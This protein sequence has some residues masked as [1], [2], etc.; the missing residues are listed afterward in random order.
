MIGFWKMHFEDYLYQKKLHEP[1]AE[2]K[3]ANM[4]AEEWTMLDRQ[5]LGAVRLSLAKNVA[6]NIINDKTTYDL[7][8][9]LSNMYEKPSALN[10][11]FLIRQSVNTK[12]KK[13]ASVADHVNEFNAI[14][15]RMNRTLNE[16]VKRFQILEEERQGNEVSLAHLRVF[17]CDSY[18]KVKDVT[19]DNLDAKSVK[20]TFI[21]YSLDEIGYCFWDSKSHKVIQSKDITF[22]EDSLYGAKAATNSSNLTMPNQ[23][24]QVVLEDSLENLA[25]KSI[26]TEHGLSLEIIQ[27]L[28]GSSYTSE[29]SENNKSFED[30]ER[31]DKEDS[32]DRAS[33]EDGGSKGHFKNQ[34]PK[35]VASRD[36]EVHMTVKDYDDAL[37][38]CVE[39]IVEDRIMDFDASFHATFFKEELEKFK[40]YSGKV[41]LAYDKTLDIARVGDVLDEEGYHVGFRN[42]Q[43]KVTKGSLVVAC[44][45][46]R[47]SLYMV[48]IPSDGIKA[49]IDGKGNKAL[50]H[51]MLGHMSEKGMKILAL[52]DSKGQKVVRSRGVTFYEDSLYGA[53]A[54]TDSSYLTKPNQMDQVVLEDS[55][56]NLA[57]KSIV[58]EHGLCSKITQSLD[59]VIL[60]M[61]ED[62][63]VPLILGRPF[64]H[65]VDAVVK[66][67]IPLEEPFSKKNSMLNSMNSWQ[68]PPKKTL[69]PNP[70]LKNNHSKK[71]TFNTDYKI[72]TSLEE[73]HMDLELKP[74]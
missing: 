40:L 73:P 14:L 13:G 1:L 36:K 35:P 7:F 43:G 57:N 17:G 47:G 5:A 66:S 37:V 32:I 48:E 8:K 9:A 11:V 74:L 3:P 44:E 20:C 64:L 45:N 6:Y 69:N 70:T 15:T 46:K 33:F 52:K 67:F 22:N 34:Y 2:A 27:S 28:G 19:R 63:K 55:P 53:K 50:W 61:E 25:N 72:K 24:D 49:T 4:K 54:T 31:S 16:R 58:A 39:N 42:Q 21:G 10:K 12:M 18:V 71:I 62:S 41:R 38:C 59:F 65:T 68:C 23:K 51:Q 26:V 56:K 60:E 30:S 29:G